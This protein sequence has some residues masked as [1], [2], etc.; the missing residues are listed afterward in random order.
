[1]SNSKE[2]LV[3]VTYPSNCALLIMETSLR[4]VPFRLL[5]LQ[6]FHDYIDIIYTGVTERQGGPRQYTI[7]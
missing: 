7:T 3:K 1:M 6:K 4:N 2:N 5:E